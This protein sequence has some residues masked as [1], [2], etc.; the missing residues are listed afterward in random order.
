MTKLK[1][2]ISVV[3]PNYN[4]KDLLECNLPSIYMALQQTPLEYEIIVSDDCSTDDSTAF[5]SKEYPDIKI[6][7]SKTNLGFSATCNKGIHSASYSLLCI[8]NT[9]VTFTKD[10][11]VN[12]LPEFDDPTLFAVKG[13]ILNYNDTFDNITGIER[14]PVLYYK[15]GFLRFDHNQDPGN[16]EMTGKLNEF[17]VL[18]GCCFVCSTDKMQKLHGFDTIFSP[19]Y[20][21]DSDLALRAIKAGYR[22]RYMPECRVFHRT[23]STINTYRKKHLRQLVSYRN[24]FLFSWHHLYGPRQ[25][26][27]H[28]LFTTFNLA[29][30]WLILDWKYY[31]AL[32]WASYREL[33]FTR[34]T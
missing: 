20:W 1:Y 34:N 25:W 22:L 12:A 33:T 15:N 6:I 30:R 28:L 8:A 14:A 26:G 5:L 24:K 4:G 10:Y 9:D 7:S 11:F 29:T 21:E 16:K 27:I 3:L 17:F 31:A 32:I 18:L 13:D 23:S 19:F 2:G